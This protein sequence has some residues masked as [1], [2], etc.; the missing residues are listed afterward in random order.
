MLHDFLLSLA[1]PPSYRGFDYL[2]TALTLLEQNPGLLRYSTK[3]LYPEIAK[4]CPDSSIVRVERDIRTALGMIWRHCPP[5]RL[6]QIMGHRPARQPK[7][8][9]FIG[10]LL[11]H[12]TRHVKAGRAAPSSPQNGTDSESASSSFLP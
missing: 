2:Y 9:E 4:Q 1:L 3:W 8:K 12:Y 7:P 10:Y 11:L 6:H 5:D